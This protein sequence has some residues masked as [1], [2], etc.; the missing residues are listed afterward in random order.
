MTWYS[1]QPISSYIAAENEAELYYETGLAPELN[2]ADFLTLADGEL[3]RLKPGYIKI[4]RHRWSYCLGR[5]HALPPAIMGMIH[6][7]G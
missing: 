4:H 3:A 6:H 1:D 2:S 7:R 5:C